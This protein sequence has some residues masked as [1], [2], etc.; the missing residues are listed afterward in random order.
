M[1]HHLRAAGVSIV[2]DARGTGVPAV[3]LRGR[4]RGGFHLHSPSGVEAGL[5]AGMAVWSVNGA[6]A[7]SGAQRHFPTLGDAVDDV[8]AWDAASVPA[9]DA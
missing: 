9:S 4:D 8:I 5:K 6:R 1:I 2:V 3:P 7:V